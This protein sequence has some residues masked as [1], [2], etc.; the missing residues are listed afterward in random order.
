MD[1]N[2]WSSSQ[3][4]A[5]SS[6][7]LGL[8]S[9]VCWKQAKQ[10]GTRVGPEFQPG[11]VL[12]RAAE[13]GKLLPWH[14]ELL[15]DSL[16]SSLCRLCLSV[17]SWK[18][19]AQKKHREIPR[20]LLQCT[21][22]SLLVRASRGRRLERRQVPATHKYN[23][24]IMTQKFSVKTCSDMLEQNWILH[25]TLVHCSFPKRSPIG[26]VDPVRHHNVI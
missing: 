12:G 8:A 21:R 4:S 2:A 19:L 9:L 18:Q 11:H 5:C 6:L 1:E 13:F 26:S 22:D 17:L 14:R 20:V 7:R 15:T 23:A 10:S 16:L 25:L 3:Q 24:S